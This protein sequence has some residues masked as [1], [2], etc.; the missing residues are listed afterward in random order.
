M[1]KPQNV[2]T[3]LLPKQLKP[4]FWEYDFRKLSWP[5]SKHIVVLKILSVGTWEDIRWLRSQ[6]TDAELA[7]WIRDRRGRGLTTRQVSFWRIVLRL[8]SREVRSWLQDPGR[9]LWDRRLVNGRAT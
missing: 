9:Q 3:E 4:L 6:I 7:Q 1:P 5:K 2:K 8:P